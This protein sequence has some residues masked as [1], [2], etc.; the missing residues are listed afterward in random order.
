MDYYHPDYIVYQEIRGEEVKVCAFCRID[1]NELTIE[2]EDGTVKEV[3]DKK[4]A[5]IAYKKYLEDIS[6][7]PGVAK[8][9]QEST[10][11]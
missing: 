5:S 6:K 11:K 8:I 3:V 4:Q 10:K 1:K 2:N 9:V 7:L